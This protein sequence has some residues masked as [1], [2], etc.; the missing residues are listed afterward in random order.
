MS[1][2]LAASPVAAEESRIAVID[3]GSNTFRLVV[4][5]YRPGGPFHL[6]DEIRDT[7]RLSAGQR[8]GRLR[9]EAIERG[10]RTAG[11]YAAF[12]RAAGIDEVV[13]VATSAIRDAAN[14]AE[15]LDALA[16]QGLEARVLSAEEEARYAYV[17][18]INATTLVDGLIV[19]VGGGSMQVARVAGR[20]LRQSMSH[21]VGAVRMTEAFLA[22][23]R[24]GRAALR[25]LRR[26]LAEELAPHAWA[27]D[28]D[29]RMVGVGGSVRTLAAMAQKRA[30]YPLSEVHGYPLT[31]DAIGELIDE[32]AALPAGQR[33]RLP[34][35]KSDRADIMLAGAVV[36][37]AVM[38]HAGAE[39]LEVC[40]HGLREGIF[41]ERF[42]A[43]AKP[44]LV[45][46]VRRSSVLNVA[47]AYRYDRQHC[48]QVAH[49][50]CMLLDQLARLG[51]HPGDERERGV[52]WAAGILHDVGVLVDYNDHHKHSYYLVLNAGLPGFRHRELAL[53]ALLVRSHR[54]AP[55]SVDP[56]GSVLGRG[57]EGLLLRLAACLRIAEQLERGRAQIVRELRCTLEDDAVRVDVVAEGDPSVA[58]WAAAQEGPTFETAFGRRLE[59]VPDPAG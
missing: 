25:A 48:E 38:E 41:F 56:L 16:R 59:I 24:P 49:L 11:L 40:A 6:V 13:A 20:E 53:V 34:G 26:H 35:L 8:R 54:K 46:D 39:R 17:G 10:A 4:F 2:R 31:R 47:A 51:L 52:L 28:Q 29:G 5:R 14:Q 3:L 9:R 57:G 45:P 23:E 18:A 15:V 44:P 7:V 55:P 36:I 21:P 33:D 42:L 32:M 50:A 22:D 27:H 1:P 37:D 30:E 19:D 58:V 43:P 12:C